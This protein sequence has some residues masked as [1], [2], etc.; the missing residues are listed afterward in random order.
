MRA[1]TALQAAHATTEWKIGGYVGEGQ[2]KV[3]FKE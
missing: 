2:H 3:V 1:P